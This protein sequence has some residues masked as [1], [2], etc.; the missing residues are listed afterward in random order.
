MNKLVKWSNDN[1]GVLTLVGIVGSILAAVFGALFAGIVI[2]IITIV[3]ALFSR[4]ARSSVNS[5]SI[6]KTNAEM[7]NQKSR[8]TPKGI[9]KAVNNQPL[10]MNK[11]AEA[12][13][14]GIM[15]SDWEVTLDGIR[16]SGKD[17]F[18]LS[19]TD[20]D[21][22]YPHIY[23]EVKKIDYPYLKI[24]RID[25]RLNIS[26]KIEYVDGHSIG[27]KDVDIKSSNRKP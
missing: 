5:E 22:I 8:L 16:E 15:V 2:L 7:I 25:E 20:A 17:M 6:G 14:K 11:I 4:P 19:L 13:Y 10:I 18:R 26:G 27:L 1:Q 3:F 24:T 9:V 12:G 23:C 21:G